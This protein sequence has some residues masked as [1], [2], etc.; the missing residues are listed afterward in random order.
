MILTSYFVDGF[1]QQEQPFD[2]NIFWMHSI[3]VGSMSRRIAEL[4]G[5][6]DTETAYLVGIIHDIGK[7]FLGHH[8]KE[9]YGSMLST[10]NFTRS[11]TY[12]AEM[13]Y[14]S[15][16]PIANW[17]SAWRSDG[18]SRR[19]IVILFPITIHPNWPLKSRS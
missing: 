8:F 11:S 1:K 5:Y 16:Q 12:S 14:S 13:E 2:M 10:I 9:E 7:V 19:C 3:S 15:A 6:G 17:G 18:T 4:V